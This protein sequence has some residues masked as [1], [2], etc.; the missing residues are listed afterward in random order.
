MKP[1]ELPIYTLNARGHVMLEVMRDYFD[2]SN[3][4]MHREI[5]AMHLDTVKVLEEKGIPY[6]QLRPA[7]VP[8]VDK[9]E[10]AFV[11]DSQDIESNWYGYEV[12]NVML[13]LY[14]K[15]STQSV[16]C[17]DILGE[18]QDLIFD[19]LQESLVLARSLKFVHGTCL[20]CVYVNNLSDAA[21][22]N[23]HQNLSKYPAYV[24]YIP[25][26]FAS[27]ARS[28]LSTCLVNTFLK[29]NGT[30]LMGHEDDRSNEEDVNMVSYPFEEYGYVVRSLQG[31]YFGV[32]LSYKIERPVMPG[33]EVDTEMSI[34]AVSTDVLPLE[35]F[36]VE[37]EAAKHEY[38]R[39]RKIGKLKKAGVDDLDNVDLSQLIR[40]KISASYI[41]NLTYLE[42]HDVVKFN[43]MVEVPH[44]DGGYP[45]RLVAS[46]EYKPVKQ[47]L[48]LITLH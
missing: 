11:F 47:T 32:Y 48:R 26:T 34:S 4:V 3:Q 18:D 21:I 19:I 30:V 25:C 2:L 20:Y 28:Y 14:D 13:P 24:G 40:S 36:E 15:R 31:A 37:V 8:S 5:Q 12:A 41:Y 16:L 44:H 10:A 33:F 42:E 43:L 17:G 7:L 22:L 1:Y 38:L 23:F 9:N 46:L 39:T 35:E 6:N 27:R 29:Y 45:T